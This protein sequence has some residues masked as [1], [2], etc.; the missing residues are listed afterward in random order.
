MSNR[1][2]NG[3]WWAGLL[4]SIVAAPLMA[5]TAP[6]DDGRAATGP[7]SQQRFQV[8]VMEGVLEN[9]VS[10]GA[11]SVS[12]QMRMVSPD[13]SLFSGPARARGYRLEGYGAF[14]AVDVPALHR[15]VSWSVRTLTQSNAELSRALQAIRRMVQAQADPRAKA[16]LEQSLRLLELQVGPS[17]PRPPVA[18]AMVTAASTTPSTSSAAVDANGAETLPQSGNATDPAAADVPAVMANPS[19]AY[20]EAVQRAIVEAM[21]E[22]GSTL[23]LG[24]DEWLTVAARENADTMLAGDLS[25]I[26][27]ITIRLKAS[28]LND[29]RAGRLTR[30]EVRRR[31]QMREF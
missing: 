28:D 6:A 27:T 22:Y 2:V 31:V 26:V 15:S 29:L 17:Y 4:C 11:Q 19:A 23:N 9:A 21:L 10:H 24:T 13:I 1:V 14:F 12:N 18:G 30:D 20:T 5:Q 8:R 16:D 25:E 3:T 7:A